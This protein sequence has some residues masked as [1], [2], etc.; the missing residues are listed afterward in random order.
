M[1]N[2]R[3]KDRIRSHPSRPE[4][5]LAIDEVAEVEM[6]TGYRIISAAADAPREVSEI[7]IAFVDHTPL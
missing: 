2:G 5:T 6:L 7:D 3:W 4:D 1:N